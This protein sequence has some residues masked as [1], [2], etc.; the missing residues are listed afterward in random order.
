MPGLPTLEQVAALLAEHHPHAVVPVSTDPFELVLWEQVAYLATDDVR[1]LAFNSLR[2][3]VGLSPEKIRG[4]TARTLQT[5]ARI[6]GSIAV[7]ER[8]ERMKKSAALAPGL[9]GLTKLPLNEARK[10]LA[11]FPM[12]GAPG[13]DRILLFTGAFNT[14]ALDSNGLRMLLRIGFGKE[15]ENYAASYRSVM[16]AIARQLP[17]RSEERIALHQRLRQHGLLL[18]KRSHPLCEQCSLRPHCRH[19]LRGP[20]T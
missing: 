3:R 17:E 12:I 5:V 8:A 13:A 2:E 10:R 9:M 6:G 15:A 18:C 16:D 20:T 14:F 4:A 11:E 19:G 7:F 1:S